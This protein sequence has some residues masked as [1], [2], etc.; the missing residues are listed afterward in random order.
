MCANLVFAVAYNVVALGLCL[1]GLVTPLL[2]AVLMPASS[3]TVVTHTIARLSGRRR[4]M[5]VVIVLVFVSLVL[6][7]RRWSCLSCASARGTSS[8]AT[9]SRCCPSTTGR[10]VA[11]PPAAAADRDEDGGGPQ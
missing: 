9:G 8:T 11:E 3:L 4:R 1:A 7:R 6:V 5:D 2:A 10:A